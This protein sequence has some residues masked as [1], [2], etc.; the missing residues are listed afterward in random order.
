MGNNPLLT[1]ADSHLVYQALR[2]LD[3]L[4]ALEYFITP[5]AMLADYILPSAGGLE[6]PLFQTHAGI[7]NIAYGGGQA[8]K[9]YYQR[10]ADY[11]F[12]RELALRMGQGERWPWETLQDSLTYTLSPT[13]VTWSQFCETGLFYQPSPYFKHEHVDKS[14]GEKRGFATPSR[15]IELSCKTLASLGY[16]SLPTP[17]I[18]PKASEDFPLIL[19]TGARKQ[20]FLGSSYRQIGTLRSIHPEPWA[21][22]SA[23]TAV[24]QGLVDGCPVIVETE[25][26]R[27]R[28]VLKIAHI[29]DNVVSVEY[30]W[31]FPELPACEPGLSGTWIS[32]ANLL[33]SAQIEAS[34]PLI[35]TW[36]FNGLPCRVYPVKDWMEKGK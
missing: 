1:H 31:W 17:V 5:T 19:I 29:R 14:T 11:F 34:D 6:R 3:L 18:P 10:Q 30:G 22:M 36:T 32:N 33:T 13:G 20:P 21:E 26:G 15:K 12:W 35:G 23:S 4:V 16:N 28:F 25:H 7:A 24:S 8:V 27:A 9:P 2:K